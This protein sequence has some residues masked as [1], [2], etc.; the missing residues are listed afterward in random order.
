[1]KPSLSALALLALAGCA[2]VSPTQVNV[3]SRIEEGALLMFYP[4]HHKKMINGTTNPDT[5]FLNKKAF[6]IPDNLAD[7]LNRA[8]CAQLGPTVRTVRYYGACATPVEINASNGSKKSLRLHDGSEFTFWVPKKEQLARQNIQA[9]YLLMVDTARYIVERVRSG[10]GYS[11]GAPSVSFGA[12]G[13]PT[14][15]YGPGGYGAPSETD[16]LILSWNYMLYDYV[17]D[18]P[19]SYGKNDIPAPAGYAAEHDLNL[20]TALFEEFAKAALRPTPVYHWWT[21]EDKEKM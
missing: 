20:W 12:G 16:V 2:V 10:G 18:A 19:V 4:L 5:I 7:S 17:A 1:M 9:R 6:P 13:T 15:S 11:G 21:D 3:T 8:A 14:V